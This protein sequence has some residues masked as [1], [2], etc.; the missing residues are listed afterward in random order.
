MLA[1]TSKAYGQCCSGGVPIS[2]TLG[3][4]V[5]DAKSWQF[6]L[7]YDYNAMNDLLEGSHVLDDNSRKRSTHS[8][9]L[10]ANYGLTKRIT[11]TAMSTFVRQERSVTTFDNQTHFTSTQGIGDGLFL[12]KYRLILPEGNSNY[13][14]SIGAGPKI[15][16]GRTDFTDQNGLALPADM[17]PGSGAWD[18]LLWS[19]FER[20]HL[21][22]KNFNLAAVFT[23]RYT[24]TN[25]DYFGVQAYR[26]GNEFSFSLQPG[27]R[28][29]LGSQ[30]FDGLLTIM[31]RHQDEDLVD[32]ETFPNSGG[33]FL[34][35]IPGLAYN[36]TPEFS[37]RFSGYIPLYRNP[38][39][40]QLTTSY[41]LIVAVSYTIR[42]KNIQINNSTTKPNKL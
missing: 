35:M 19:H 12:F 36:L 11:L 32:G 16:I 9:L 18:L 38:G 30:V 34:Y 37:F 42:N 33:D 13:S 14:F 29:S 3:L 8:I 26:F 6:L 2:G 40:T 41:K 21:F 10:E 27:Y 25:S 39:G 7:T 17:Q 4:S 20:Y 31:Y 23:Y 24:G 15:P 22:L 1:M 28:F 5:S